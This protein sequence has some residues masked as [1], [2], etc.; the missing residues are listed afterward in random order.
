MARAAALA[1]RGSRGQEAPATREAAEEA[2]RRAGRRAPRITAAPAHPPAPS[3]S[4]DQR[5]K[6]QRHRR[7]GNLVE[8]APE[9]V[10]EEAAVLAQLAAQIDPAAAL[11]GAR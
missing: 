4:D 6:Q 11:A 7:Q 3:P 5:C 10:A 9:V 2:S 8:P 1:R